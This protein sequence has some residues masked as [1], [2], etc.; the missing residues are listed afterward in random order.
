MANSDFGES[1]KESRGDLVN[2]AAVIDTF[3][4]DVIPPFSCEL[5]VGLEKREPV[6]VPVLL[7]DSVDVVC[8]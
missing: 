5:I 8:S 7:I 4:S 6:M 1:E 2:P 3:L